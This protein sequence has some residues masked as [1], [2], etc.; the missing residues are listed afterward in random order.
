MQKES[1]PLW[2]AESPWLGLWASMAWL[3]SST[4]DITKGAACEK[5]MKKIGPSF[6]SDKKGLL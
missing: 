5:N 3:S 1:H 6:G 4:N 2:V